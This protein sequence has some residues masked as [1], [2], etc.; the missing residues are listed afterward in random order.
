M[1]Q[2]TDPYRLA[3]ESLFLSRPG[4][5]S[6]EPE[7]TARG[8]IWLAV[9]GTASRTGVT[10]DEICRV[11]Q[12]LAQPSW[13]PSNSLIDE[14]VYDLVSEENLTAS[15][16]LTGEPRFVPTAKGAS[17]FRRLMT[18]R[19]GHVQSP[20][21]QACLR[22]KLAFLDLLPSRDRSVLLEKIARHYER[23]LI[24]RR[25]RRQ[26]FQTGLFGQSWQDQ[27]TE[28]MRRDLVLLR[29][30]AYSMQDE[31]GGP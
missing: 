24:V 23:E 2:V 1:N 9:L 15:P 28:S 26:P 6:P 5:G 18:T 17:N 27:A 4:D 31:A 11:A 8:A 22:F 19:I 13:E 21:G 3:E 14:A 20:F 29:T 30:F 10:Q 12:H 7:M 16:P 25:N